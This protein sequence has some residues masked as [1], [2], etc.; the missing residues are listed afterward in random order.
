MR[1]V[2][3]LFVV[4][5]VATP[6]AAQD[7]QPTRPVTMIVPFAA[8][9][10]VDVLGRVLAP[11]L[12]ELLGQQVVVENVGGGGGM[13]G[14]SRVARGAPDGHIF[15]LGSISTHTFNQ[16]LFKQPQYN[17]LTDFTPV[18]LIAETPLVLV[19]RKDLPREEPQGVRRPRQG[20][21]RQADLRH[22]PA[23]ARPIT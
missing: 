1:S 10:Q 9:G 16:T 21:R 22:R 20:A 11:R 3:A 19:T 5:I 6:A 23:S 17:V 18:A 2:A 4:L 15:V 12:S 7:W 8:G 14:S 13:I